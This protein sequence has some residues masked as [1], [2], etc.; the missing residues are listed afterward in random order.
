MGKY[1]VHSSAPHHPTSVY[2]EYPIDPIQRAVP[3]PAA[4][5]L[6]IRRVSAHRVSGRTIVMHQEKASQM[7]QSTP[8][9]VSAVTVKLSRLASVNYSGKI[10]LTMAVMQ[11]NVAIGISRDHFGRRDSVEYVEIPL[12]LRLGIP[13][14]ERYTQHYPSYTHHKCQRDQ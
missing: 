14:L 9:S 3:H 6:S 1:W 12:A 7:P 4:L 11:E 8:C 5:I 2:N 13:D 10:G